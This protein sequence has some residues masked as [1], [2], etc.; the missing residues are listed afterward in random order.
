MPPEIST[1]PAPP[2][3]G[4]A[5]PL[6]ACGNCG[7]PL[8]GKYCYACGQPVQAPVRHLGSVLADV[9]DSVF[10]LDARLFRTLVPLYLRPGRLTLDYFAG[11]R[12]RYVSPFRLVFLLAIVAFFAIQ[13]STRASFQPLAE[14][15]GTTATAPAT[16]ADG[17]IKLDNG[18][19][20]NRRTHPLRVRYLPGA[21]NEWLNDLLGNAQR[22]M[23]AMGSGSA[24][25]RIT[26][27][28]KFLLGMVASAPTVL[29][30]LLP[31]FALLL[32]VF[33]IFRKRLY[34]EHLIVAMHSHA[35]LMLSM[36]VLLALA[37]LR[38]WLAPH[39]AWLAVPLVLLA[40]AAWVW[41]LTYL[42]V[43]QKRVYRQGWAM[44]CVK[45]WCIGWCYFWLVLAA[46]AVAALLSLASG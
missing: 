20:W 22:Q 13:V 2:A 11:R 1:P 35:F 45:F 18:W 28:R 34:M 6:T 36:L 4:G 43:M 32:K 25:D 38:A 10:N 27:T 30:V 17:T 39:G 41:L 33:F 37:T 19:T 44:T 23:H 14:A 21:V 3:V 8:Y 29:F 5:P 40:A 12:A 24:A 9:S 46:V 31:F 26:A 7:A 15:T 42:L 16:D